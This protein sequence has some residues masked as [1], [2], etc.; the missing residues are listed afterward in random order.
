[1]ASALGDMSDTA[2]VVAVGRWRNDALAEIYRRHAG[3][4]GAARRGAPGH[5]AGLLRRAYL[6]RSGQPS[7]RAR[8]HGEEQDQDGA[9]P[10]ARGAV[11]GW[12]G[13]GMERLMDHDE[14]AELLGAFALDAV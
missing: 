12:G 11:R 14:I 4:V 2:L 8:R 10:A 13:W 1:M 9:A 3:A 6:P 7:G 5:R